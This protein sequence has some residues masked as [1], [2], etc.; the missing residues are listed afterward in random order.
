VELYLIKG[1][2]YRS[3]FLL[4]K[5]RISNCKSSF[6]FLALA[7]IY[8]YLLEPYFPVGNYKALPYLYLIEAILF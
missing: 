7:L 6:L 4:L 5:T 8:G 2:Y 3:N 1:V